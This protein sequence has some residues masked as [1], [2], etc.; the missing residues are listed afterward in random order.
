MKSSL[1][2]VCCYFHKHLRPHIVLI[3]ICICVYIYLYKFRPP[4]QK[5]LV[6]PSSS[7]DDRAVS[8]NMTSCGLT[9]DGDNCCPPMP[10]TEIKDFKLPS[11]SSP[12]RVRPA[13][14]LA[15][16]KYIAKYKEA[17]RRMK[18]LPDEDP[19]SFK[20]QAN[21]HCA[22]CNGAY[23][24]V[25]YPH[26]QVH[27][28]YGW[29]FFPFHR[30]QLYFFEKILGMLLEDPTFAIP[31]WNWDNPPG[32]KMPDMFVEDSNSSLYDVLRNADHL[33]KVVDCNYNVGDET[34]SSPQESQE[35]Q[36]SINLKTIYRQMVSNSKNAEL[37]YG[38][39]Y[40]AGDC[41]A[42]NGSYGGPVE[43]CPHNTI[44]SWCG[45]PKNGEEDMGIFATAARDP[46]FYS[47]HGNVDRMWIIW[48][49]NITTDPE[50]RKC[51][52][53]SK[54]WLDANFIFYDEN[55]QPVRAYVRDSLDYEKLGYVYEK[56]D[57]PWFNEKP[58]PRKS[59]KSKKPAVEF[60]VVLDKV[61]SAVVARPNNSTRRDD[62]EE[63]LVI[64]GIE[65]EK[66]E[67]VKFDVHINDD[68]DSPCGPENTEFAGSFVHVQHSHTHGKKK[69][70]KM[71]SALRLGI[72][73]LLKDLEADGDDTVLVT[74]VPRKGLVTIRG[75][76]IELIS[77]S[78][79]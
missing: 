53:D 52:E 76:V 3:S 69:T 29:L 66:D 40:R 22:Y 9:D 65:F 8:T 74:L 21:L 72:T 57:I 6:P 19:L 75:I 59:K 38:S 20:Q 41:D 10:S 36:E 73:D 56:V 62:K 37:F 11:Q 58:T 68:E 48:R 77:C 70:K 44:H 64:E 60:P 18:A 4:I 50:K 28:H 67:A 49:E 1:K 23:S 33:R 24:Q 55:R 45:D 42:R 25:G 78:G 46:I 2:L 34:Y 31:F 27:I 54:D 7:K 39:A 5:C 47:H 17:I 51:V 43:N 30:Y 26:C 15:D 79:K 13:A 35:S 61:I 32:M 14:H 63:V 16:E 12:M 71:N